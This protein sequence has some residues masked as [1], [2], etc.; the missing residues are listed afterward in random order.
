MIGENT[1]KDRETHCAHLEDIHVLLKEFIVSKRKNI[2]IEK[3]ATG[4]Y[5]YGKSA[6]AL[7]LV[8]QIMTSDEYILSMRDKFSIVRVKYKPSTTFADK[9]SKVSSKLSKKVFNN[10]SQKTHDDSIFK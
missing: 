10:L 7:N 6:L 4:E 5:W 9:I 3:V 2:D 1:D 8:D